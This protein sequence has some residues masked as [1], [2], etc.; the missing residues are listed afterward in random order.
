M[1]AED[2]LSVSEAIADVLTFDGAE[3][4]F[5]NHEERLWWY[6]FGYYAAGNKWT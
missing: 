5:Y 1:I 4:F 2:E 3:A 6:Y